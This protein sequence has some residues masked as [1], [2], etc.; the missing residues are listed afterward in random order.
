MTR[1]KVQ[2]MEKLLLFSI[3]TGVIARYNVSAWNCWGKSGNLWVC[4]SV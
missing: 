4:D 2:S 1:H 3:P